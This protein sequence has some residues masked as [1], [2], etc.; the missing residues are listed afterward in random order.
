MLN[1][2][3]KGMSSVHNYVIL[4]LGQLYDMWEKRILGEKGLCF[5]CGT[6]VN[7]PVYL[8]LKFQVCLNQSWDLGLVGCFCF[9][10]SSS[11]SVRQG[12]QYVSNVVIPDDV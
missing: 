8:E 4:I 3:E 10:P 2:T 6:E 1:R 12:E 7:S 5:T 11:P 9:C